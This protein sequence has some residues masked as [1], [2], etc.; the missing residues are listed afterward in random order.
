M[1]IKGIEVIISMQRKVYEIMHGDEE[2]AWVDSTRHCKIYQQSFM[3]YNLYLDEDED[4]YTL[5][6]NVINFNYW[7][8]TRVLT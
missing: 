7:C 2:V 8:A 5:V 1:L 6:N 3:P 4:L